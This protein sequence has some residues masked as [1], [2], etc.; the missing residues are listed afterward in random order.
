MRL[1]SNQKSGCYRP[2]QPR[3]GAELEEKPKLNHEIERHFH[4]KNFFLKRNFVNA[5]FF[6]PLS[7]FSPKR[8]EAWMVPNSCVF[9]I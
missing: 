2:C 7:S 4:L 8:L 3:Q 6:P 1:E 9:L 5:S